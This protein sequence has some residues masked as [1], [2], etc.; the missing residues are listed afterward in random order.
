VVDLVQSLET[1]VVETGETVKETNLMLLAIDATIGDKLFP[2]L[3]KAS[4]TIEMVIDSVVAVN[5]ALEAVNAIPFVTVPT[6]TAD[7]EAAESGIIEVQKEIEETR[8][9]IQTAK[10]E[11]VESV[12]EPISIRLIEMDHS[13]QDVL[14]VSTAFE[15]QVVTSRD[16]I[17]EV[18]E[19]LP[20]W[21]DLA[22]V[23]MTLVMAWLIFTQGSLLLLSYAYIR[24]GEFKITLGDGKAEDDTEEDLQGEDEAG[25]A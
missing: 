6:L 23:I 2:L 12:V 11:A 7:L 8:N 17:A 24:T 1:T 15:S 16:A 14:G 5:E 9:T 20:G 19:K 3:E 10:E 22:S 13:L 4:D 21:I 25:D 18:I